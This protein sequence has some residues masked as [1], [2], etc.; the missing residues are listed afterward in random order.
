VGEGARNQFD[1][2]P[3]AKPEILKLSDESQEHVHLMVEENGL[4]VLPYSKIGEDTVEVKITLSTKTKLHTTVPGMPILAHLLKSRVEV[5]IDQ[6][7][8]SGITEQNGSLC[9]T[10][11]IREQGYAT[12]NKGVMQGLRR[13]TGKES[14]LWMY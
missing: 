13:N 1:I 7:G 4:G 8:L 11:F 3:V 6:H 5:I 2:Y 10:R 14:Q 12:D 9:R